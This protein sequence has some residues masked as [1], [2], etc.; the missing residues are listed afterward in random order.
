M[1][2]Y[3]IIFTE[4]FFI[5]YSLFCSLSGKKI[6]VDPGHGGSDPGSGCFGVWEEDFTLAV[7]LKLKTYLENDGATVVITRTTD[8]D[9]SLTTRYSLFNSNNCHIAIS[10]HN[11]AAGCPSTAHGVETYYCSLNAYPSSSKTLATKV[12]NRSLSIVKNDSRGVKECLD[13]GRGFH[14]AMTRYPNMPATLSENYFITNQSECSTIHAPDSGRDKVARAHYAATC[15]YFNVTPNLPSVAYQA[16]LVSFIYPQ[17][18]YSGDRYQVQ[19]YMLNEGTVTWTTDKTKLVVVNP[20]GKQSVFYNSSTWLS[21]DSPCFVSSNVGQNS[22]GL[23]SFYVKAPVVQQVTQYTEYFNL[24]QTGAGYF[25]DYGGPSDT[26]VKMVVTVY[27]KSSSGSGEPGGEG[28]FGL[29]DIVVSKSTFV[30]VNNET[31]EIAYYVTLTTT[32]LQTLKIYDSSNICVKT[33][34]DNVVVSSG[35]K[36]VIWD[37]KND[38][39]EFVST[40]KYK[41]YLKLTQGG[42]IIEKTANVY[43][44]CDKPSVIVESLEP[45][46]NVVDNGIKIKVFITSAVELAETKVNFTLVSEDNTTENLTRELNFSSQEQCY[47][48]V[49][50]DI[51]Q[52]VKKINYEIVVKDVHN[53]S[54]VVKSD[55]IIIEPV[56]IENVNL[57]TTTKI[58]LSDGNPDDAESSITIPVQ[59]TGGS[60]QVIFKK[61]NRFTVSKISNNKLVD[62][63]IGYPVAAY[64]ISTIPQNLSFVSP[65]K[66]SLLYPDIDNDGFDDVYYLPVERLKIFYWNNSGWELVGGEVDKGQKIVSANVHHCSVYALFPTKENVVLDPQYFKPPKI[67][68]YTQNNKCV[69]FKNITNFQP[70]TEIKIFDLKGR[71]VKKIVN[72]DVWDFTDKNGSS[73]SSG[74]YI[75]QYKFGN[76]TFN[77]TI[78]VVK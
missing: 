46:L 58:K 51:P 52:N 40:G 12:L 9:V 73:V 64:E 50:T 3:I 21:Y 66:I 8:T 16:K 5:S 17:S 2:K 74:I 25:S 29:S 36:T 22:Q 47:Y 68:S 26:E 77:G 1:K 13:A 43:V 42:K 15:D 11:N 32:A 78:S 45:V 67:V 75:Y 48:T 60:I 39:N 33:I 4:M 54:S 31:I 41:I 70:N 38:N 55:D 72:N 65:V 34:Y 6:G 30:P 59:K 44:Y 61:L 37:G 27:P 7:G 57:N 56:H 49:L 35:N 76:E 71:I 18:M 53:S 24:Y 10:I 69:Q 62:P 23:F 19:L 20:R 14:F 63:A 28:E